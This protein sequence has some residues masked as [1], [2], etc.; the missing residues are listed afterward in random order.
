VTTQRE[1]HR[2]SLMGG[3]SPMAMLAAC[4]AEHAMVIN[5]VERQTRAW[6]RKQVK[7]IDARQAEARKILL[8]ERNKKDAGAA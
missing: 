5:F 8:Q 6:L 7:E 1:V 2:R 3:M 4:S